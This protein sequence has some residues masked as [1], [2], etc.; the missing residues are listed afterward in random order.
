[1][2][3][4]SARFMEG[5]SGAGLRRILGP[6]AAFDRPRAGVVWQTTGPAGGF[7]NGARRRAE[8]RCVRRDIL[9]R[10]WVSCGAVVDD[11]SAGGAAAFSSAGD[12][13]R[14][15]KARTRSSRSFTTSR[16]TNE[17]RIVGARGAGRVG[18][19]VCD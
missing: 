2:P 6:G 7:E 10:E 8:C 12:A 19:A 11:S 15:Y 14:I 1:M 4:S 5:E 3:A 16:Q 18:D 13:W 9:L 17:R